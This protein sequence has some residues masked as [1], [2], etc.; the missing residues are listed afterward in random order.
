MWNLKWHF[1][2][3]STLTSIIYCFRYQLTIKIHFIHEKYSYTSIFRNFFAFYSSFLS[4]LNMVMISTK[5][6]NFCFA[7]TISLDCR[8]NSIVR[9]ISSKFFLNFLIS[10]PFSQTLIQ[11]HFLNIPFLFHSMLMDSWVLTSESF[12]LIHKCGIKIIKK[13]NMFS[14]KFKWSL[15]FR[16]YQKYL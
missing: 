4:I 8:S 7:C 5:E 11:Y 2:N 12:F 10:F 13:W 9:S 3:R 1:K 16:I 15:K 14:I 6:K